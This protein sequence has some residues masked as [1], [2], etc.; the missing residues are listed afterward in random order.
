[1]KV[2]PYTETVAAVRGKIA[3]YHAA[4]AEFE[5]DVTLQTAKQALADAE[6]GKER[7]DREDDSI[8]PEELVDRR[9]DAV[10]QV[11]VAKIRVARAEKAHASSKGSV[12]FILREAMRIAVAAFPA[13]AEALR[14]KLEA[15][16]VRVYGAEIVGNHQ[17]SYLKSLHH[18]MTERVHGTRRGLEKDTS[19][20]PRQLIAHLEKALAVLED[21]HR[22]R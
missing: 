16:A 5:K 18:Q 19:D 12:V 14:E 2:A 15:G 11:E 3:E 6:V 21:V 9:L 7:A 17:K 20:N 8:D 13:A 4:A 22:D 1:M 10:R